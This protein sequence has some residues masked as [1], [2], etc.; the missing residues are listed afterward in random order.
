MYLWR[1]VF[2]RA[3]WIRILVQIGSCA[4]FVTYGIV[5]FKGMASEKRE[6]WMLRDCLECVSHE[7]QCWVHCSKGHL[8]C[9]ARTVEAVHS[10][11][12]A[13]CVLVQGRG[14]VGL[15]RY[16]LWMYL[17]GEPPIL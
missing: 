2:L 4:G 9:F 11:I 8:I 6:A 15:T 12:A 1:G 16:R 13:L 3:P 7:P 5:V 10:S 17:L 14:F